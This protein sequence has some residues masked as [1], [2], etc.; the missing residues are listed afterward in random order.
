VLLQL[1]IQ[2][3]ALIEF[4]EVNFSDGF[5]T[6][7]GETG[8]GKSLI[9]GALGLIQGKRAE[10]RLVPKNGKKCIVEGIFKIDKYDLKNFFDTQELDYSDEI[11]IR[12]ELSTTGKSRAF[13]NDE[14]VNLATLSFLAEK[15]IDIHSQH[16]TLE[17]TQTDFQ[18]KVLDALSNTQKEIQTYKIGFL[19]YQKEVSKYNKLL[20]DK[21]QLQKE[22]DFNKHLFLEL[23]ESNL[24]VNEQKILEEELDI[25]GSTEQIQHQLS[26][27]L[28]GFTSEQV[29]VLDQL[30]VIKTALQ[31]IAPIAP[32]YSEIHKRIESLCIELDDIQSQT[33]NQLDNL[34]TDPEK[35]TKVSERLQHIYA[36]QKKHG[37]NSI[38]QL[39]ELQDELEEKTQL[40]QNID[41][42]LKNQQSIIKNLEE[43]LDKL[44]KQIHQKRKKSL[45]V[46][47]KN[48]EEILHQLGM[49]NAH[50]NPKLTLSNTF[51]KFGK[52]DFELLF[53]ANKGREFDTLKNVASGGELSRIVL[54]IKIILSRHIALPTIIFD[55]IDTGVSGEIAG[56]M[57]NLLSQM[58]KSQQVFSITHLPQIAAKGTRQY[59]VY[60]QDNA[61][62]TSTHL[63]T[64]SKKERIHEIAEM[65]GGK[66][67]TQAALSHAESLLCSAATPK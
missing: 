21:A 10:N 35:L 38:T 27:A 32:S 40:S 39:L 44:C 47:V 67:L 60:K 28:E 61:Q 4:L 20:G 1:N 50:F 62:F 16:Q 49:N 14:L 33:Q 15:L 25:L 18:F 34:D 64:L 24:Q 26:F 5:S 57:A 13:I 55:E 6:I 42:H 8:A 46:L 30:Y 48:L 65:I 56:K 37:L 66:K 12:R 29:G 2:N 63:K 58:G 17:I 9:L 19:K 23:Q 3:F 43:K 51:N 52:S 22:H 36:L 53:S 54:A 11:L 59:K 41:K 7:T 45:P 31:K